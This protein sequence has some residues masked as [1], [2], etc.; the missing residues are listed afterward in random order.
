MYIGREVGEGEGRGVVRE[1]RGEKGIVV[2][3][4]K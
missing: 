3:L 1:K 4:F 2:F